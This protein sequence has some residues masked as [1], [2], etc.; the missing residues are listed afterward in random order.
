MK[1]KFLKPQSMARLKCGVDQ[2]TDLSLSSLVFQNKKLVKDYSVRRVD[3]ISNM[4]K[5]YFFTWPE[6]KAMKSKLAWK[7]L[8]KASNLYL[9][10]YKSK[11]NL[12]MYNLMSFDM[13][14]KILKTCRY[15]C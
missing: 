5:L 8:N 11:E 7:D 9:N 12:P 1:N 10:K 4:K 2:T 6:T 14:L 15:L 3:Q 13:L